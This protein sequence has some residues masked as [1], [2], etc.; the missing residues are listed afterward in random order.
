M[1]KYRQ[2]RC[3]S[4]LALGL[5]IAVACSSVVAQDPNDDGAQK[6]VLTSLEQRMQQKID[7]TFSDTDIDQVIRVIAE[8]AQ[9]NIIKSPKVTGTVTATLTNVPLNEALK[10]ILAAQGY[11]YAVDENV[12]RIAPLSELGE[13]AERFVSKIYRIT[14]ADVGA[15]EAALKKFVSKQGV[16]SSSPSTSNIIVTDTESKIKA[17]DTF[18]E[19]IDRITPQVLVEARVYDITSRDTLDLGIEW[20]AGRNTTIA[21]ALGSNPTGDRKPFST[22]TFSADT[23]KTSTD[24]MGDLRLGWLSNDFDLDAIVKAKQENASAKLLANPRILVLDNETALFDILTEIPYS[25]TTYNG[26]A[27]TET[28][29]FKSVGVKLQVVPHVTRDGMVRLQ[30]SPEFSVV[31]RTEKFTSSNVPVVDTRMVKTI[32]LVKSGNTVV[33]GGLRKKDVSMQINKIP[34]LG[35]IPV[36]GLLFRFKGE[37][38]SVTELLVFITPKI[39]SEPTGMTPS[40]TQAYGATEFPIPQ[41]MSTK[42]ETQS[43]EKEK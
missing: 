33:I 17:V 25:E 37:S 11:G 21:D 9:L 23:Q 12:V 7:I 35:D 14:Y 15:V 8:K 26:T 41:A 24:F 5:I 13:Q 38:T 18:I 39:I 43:V 31:S 4:V 27:S 10:N 40:E 32:A 20:E 36:V 1:K 6:Q 28:I 19:E 3:W 34:L 42:A 16:V 29:R 2:S 30:I 22:G